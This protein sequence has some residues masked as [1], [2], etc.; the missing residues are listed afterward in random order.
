MKTTRLAIR[1][2]LQ[3]PQRR[4][5][6]PPASSTDK[7]PLQT[8]MHAFAVLEVL[9]RWPAGIRLVDLSRAVDL[10]RTTVFRLV[11]TMALLGVVTQT[12]GNK[13]YR[14]GAGYAGGPPKG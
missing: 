6:R 7:V 14:I 9:A 8:V 1:P 5:R 10:H 3:R 4:S 12:E 13:L 2:D 11:K